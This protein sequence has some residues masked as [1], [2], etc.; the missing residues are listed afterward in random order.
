MR[1]LIIFCIFLFLSLQVFPQ[2]LI[3]E[4]SSANLNG[5]KDEDSVYSD[6]IELYNNTSSAINL[7]GYHLSDQATF[8]SKWTFPAFSLPPYSHQLVF[9]SGKNRTEIPI[10]FETIIPYPTSWSY[11]V[12][13]AEIG[14]NWK[15]T[16]FDDTSWSKGLS[17]FG[18][19][20]NDDNTILS[21]IVSVY[22][23]KE[24]TISSLQDV[25]VL[26]FS[27]DYD[28]GFVAYINGH[29]IA[30]NNLGTT[31]STVTYNQVTGS[32]I[33]EATMYSGGSPESFVIS[34]FQSFLVEGVNVL[35][36]QGH[37]SAPSSSDLSLIP[38]LTVAYVGAG[39]ANYYPSYL[40]FPA[41]QLH[42]NFKIS[43]EGESLFLSRPD[44]SFSDSLTAT[45]LLPDISF[46]RKPDGGNS[47]QYFVLST[48]GRTNSSAGYNTLTG[49]SVKFSF[50]G[51]YFPGGLSVQLS[52]NDPLDTIVYTIDGSEPSLSGRLYTKAIPVNSNTIL[53]AKAVNATKLPGVI[54]TN[55]YFTKQHTLPVVCLSTDPYNLWDNDSGIYVLGSFAS[56]EYPFFGANF[57]QDWEKKGNMEFY[58]ENGVRQIN[59]EIGIKIFGNYSRA[60]P[61]KSMSL[62]ARSDYGKGSFDYK[63]FKDKPISHFE[64]L[65][66]RNSG[67]DWAEGFVR[68]GLTSTLIRDMDIDRMAYQPVVVYIN[69]EYWGILDLREKINPNYLAENHFVNP[70]SVNLLESTGI[71]IDGSNTE[72]QKLVDNLNSHTNLVSEAVYQEVAG[73]MDLNNYIQYQLTQIYINNHD[74][75]GNNIRFWNTNDPDSKWRWIIFDTDF[76]FSIWDQS[77]WTFNTLDFAMELNGPGWPN[78]PWSTLLFRRM[79][80]NPGFKKEFVIQYCDR[81]N[82]SFKSDKVR[83]TIDSIKALYLPEMDEHFLRWGTNSDNWNYNYQTIKY[84]ANERPAFARNHMQTKLLLSAQISVR[85]EVSPAGSGTVKLNSV[86]PET[87]PFSGIYF[88][89]IPIK[90]TA[91]PLPGYKFVRWEGT[92]SST[93]ETID[94]SMTGSGTF[95]AVFEPAGVEDIRVVINEI[96]YNSSLEKDAKD[97]IEL[98]NAGNTPVNMKNWILSDAGAEFGY[99]IPTDIIVSPGK[100]LVVCKD[101]AA[102][103]SFYP[104]VAN[105]TGD[106]LFG[107]SSTGDDVNLFNA[108]GVLV[109]WV[110]FAV[111]APWP[112]GA[113]GTGSSI[114]LV[115]PLA[116]NNMGS[117]WRESANGGTPGN[118]NLW[119]LPLSSKEETSVNVASMDCFPSPFTDFTTIRIETPE[120]GDYSLEIY[121]LKGRMVKIL[122]D[123]KV[124]QG[125]YYIDWDGR[126]T[127]ND[128][129]PGGVYI[130]R[131][132][133]GN[134][135]LNLKVV[136]LNN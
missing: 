8:L 121:D 6:W 72:Y 94:Y 3:N 122:A 85:I 102:F 28:D 48:P 115:N 11:L 17:G 45:Q 37:N 84:Y 107:L 13:K 81:L 65:V 110:N 67:N 125:A 22:V 9:A 124:E 42:T 133:G 75:P 117:N 80:T 16:G 54:T 36:V 113:N 27:V 78:P 96:N 103:R 61:Q 44:S 83:A 109:D 112:I 23:R 130:I 7:E 56:T 91:M 120:P 64:S 111:N 62:F 66:M 95:K 5:V 40:A 4:F 119:T 97:W 21:N 39:H 52:T 105:S 1:Q 106:I 49:D 35:A 46:G 24:F 53:R 82:T 127:N 51:G 135:R 26:V 68:D 128:M 123:Q 10:S 55:T 50:S 74:W 25:A 43:S 114:E 34:D 126:D 12:P 87:Y 79:M 134:L 71:I 73:K 92:Q 76:G 69:G 101:N 132:S 70:D 88:K 86:I 108:E 58:D 20:D 30:R 89:N 14:N 98:Y 2:L 77:A 131:L 104:D 47:W 116:D 15:S 32:L 93:S 59:Q 29:E 57:W 31:G 136:K 38:I 129:L 90:M 100:Y 118:L 99:T 18:Y 41:K 33:R 60:N 63:F 19:S